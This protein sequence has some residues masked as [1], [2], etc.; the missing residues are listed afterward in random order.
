MKIVRSSK[1]ILKYQ[2]DLKNKYLNQLFSDYKEDLQYFVDLIWN[3]KI[4]LE[5]YLSS[6]LLPNNK[7]KHSQWKQ[8]LYKNASEI[9]RANQK[10]KKTSKPEIKNIGINIDSRLFDLQF[11]KSEE[12][13]I[14]CKI[15]LPY[16]QDNKKRAIS[17][18]LPIK[19]HKHSLK[20]KNWKR[21]STIK[22]TR[23]SKGNFYIS[24]VYQK[25][26][27]LKQNGQKLGVDIGYKKLITTS[28]NQILGTNFQQL[29]NKIARCKQNSKHQKRLLL[30]RN[31][32]INEIC[33]KLDINNLNHIIVENLKSLKH[34]TKQNKSLS[35]SFMR[36]LQYWTYPKVIQKLRHISEENGIFLEQVQPEYTSQ[37]C[38][39]CGYTS[40]NSRSGELFRC[41]N[42][43]Y[44]I[45]ADLNAAINIRNRGVYNPSA[46]KVNLI[47]SVKIS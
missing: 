13:D 28:N 22:L 34:K 31:K 44:E 19:N 17:I 9:I 38:S 33:N 11:K 16:F 45:D 32:Q 8:I 10:R 29:C 5:K 6:K 1:H 4:P 15:R 21:L 18:N 36:K 46:V 42:C 20:F 39:S 43:G 3:K 27:D 23:T 47:D 2:T 37:I 7:I 12:F 40:K 41:I 14:Y 26:I 35:S 24:F 25:E 30:E